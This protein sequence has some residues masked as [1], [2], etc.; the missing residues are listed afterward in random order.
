MI[1]RRSAL[2]LG[3]GGMLTGAL[4]GCGFTPVYAPTPDGAG[5][6]PTLAAI[7]V[8]PIYERPGQLLSESLKAR[9]ASDSGV[10]HRFDLQVFFSITAEGQG[11]LSGTQITRVR[12]T[13]AANWVLTKTDPARTK[14]T[15]GGDRVS[16]GVDTFD[17]QYFATDLGIE[18]AQRRIADRIAEK[19]V[20][21][22]ATW[23]RQNPTAAG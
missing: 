22:L 13:G 6:S 11:I 7:E 23:F 8:K 20:L 18:A 14:L 9:L 10:P 2:L 15:E 16:D 4:A 1:R 21:R 12:I 19:I 3:C 17:S 5:T